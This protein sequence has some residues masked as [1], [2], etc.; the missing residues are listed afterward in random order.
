MTARAQIIRANNYAMRG[1]RAPS[2]PSPSQ[3][4]APTA[5]DTTT[6]VH[7]YWQGAV[8]A[9]TYSIERASAAEGPW[10]TLCTRCVTDRDDGFADPTGARGNWYRVIPFNLVGSRGAPSRSVQAA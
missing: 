8:G 6:G 10:K 1:V 2:L 9:A 4:T 5:T 7:V 3:P